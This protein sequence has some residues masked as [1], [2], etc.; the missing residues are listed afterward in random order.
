VSYEAI[1]LLILLAVTVAATLGNLYEKVD[2]LERRLER[3]ETRDAA[4]GEPISS[5][6]PAHWRRSR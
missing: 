3:F 4:A 5:D 2:R 6:A 1:G